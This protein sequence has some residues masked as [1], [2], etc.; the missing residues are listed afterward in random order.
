MTPW[1]LEEDAAGRSVICHRAP[2]RFTAFWTSGADERAALDVEAWH[3]PDAFDD[4]A[5]L[6]LYGFQWQ[7][8]RPDPETF[9]RLMREAVAFLDEWIAGQL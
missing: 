3:D 1:T 9:A 6:C 5:R 2:P 7:D 8:E 4:D